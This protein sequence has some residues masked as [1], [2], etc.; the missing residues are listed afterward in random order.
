MNK[1][2]KI[3]IVIVVLIFAIP[4]V[5]LIA[6]IGFLALSGDTESAQ[7]AKR[8]VDISNLASIAELKKSELGNYPISTQCDDVLNHLDNPGGL[9]TDPDIQNPA[10][11]VGYY[12]I[13]DATGNEYRLIARLDNTEHA[14]LQEP[15]QRNISNIQ[16]TTPTANCDCSPNRTN[17]NYCIP[18]QYGE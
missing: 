7:D 9:P 15:E 4:V 5:L 8:I 1:K 3:I 16:N 14:K 2:T 18:L 12:Y 10:L 6:T 13:T 17:G 11:Q